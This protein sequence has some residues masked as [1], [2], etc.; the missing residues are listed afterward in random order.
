[1]QNNEILKNVLRTGT[2][3]TQN[4]DKQCCLTVKTRLT[5][6]KQTGRS[7]DGRVEFTVQQTGN[8]SDSGKKFPWRAEDRSPTV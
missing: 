6:T 1:M 2:A 4:N 3:N 7:R 8:K 5:N